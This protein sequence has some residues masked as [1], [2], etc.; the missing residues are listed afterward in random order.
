MN[1]FSDIE[2]AVLQSPAFK[3]ALAVDRVEGL[4]G[5][6]KAL[7]IVRLA[8]E[9]S[10]SR[11]CVI[12]REANQLSEDIRA[13]LGDH[14]TE[15]HCIPDWGESG[16]IRRI[17][18][19]EVSAGSLRSEDRFAR[20]NSKSD[21]SKSAGKKDKSRDGESINAKCAIGNEQLA[22]K[23]AQA[24][25]PVAPEGGEKERG[26]GRR[27]D[28][29]RDRDGDMAIETRRAEE[30]VVH[31]ETKSEILSGLSVLLRWRN[32]PVSGESTTQKEIV[33]AAPIDELPL[34]DLLE[35]QTVR[36]RK[37]RIASL[38][39]N[40]RS[41]HSKDRF[42]RSDRKHIRESED[43]S[44]NIRTVKRGGAQARMPVAPEGGE[45]ERGREGDRDR[46][47]QI[48]LDMFVR[49]LDEVGF[50]RVGTVEEI[51]EF[52]VRGGIADLWGYG[53]RFPVRIEWAADG[54]E[55]IREFDPL[56]QTSI[57]ALEEITVMPM[58]CDRGNAAIR[59][60][61]SDDVLVILDEIPNAKPAVRDGGL[62]CLGEGH[63][64]GALPSYQGNMRVFRDVME[65]L[66]GYNVFV[67]CDNE[68][69]E[70]R[71]NSIFG[72]WNHPEQ[73]DPSVAKPEVK[74]GRISSG[75][76][77]ADAKLAVFS[78]ADIFGHKVRIK[79]RHPFKGR[80]V[81]IED[82]TSL[83][84]GDIVVHIDYG[85]GIY[86]GLDK[87]AIDDSRTDC[88][89]IEYKNGDK[90]YIP[91][92]KFHLVE[93]WAGPYEHAPGLTTL[94]SGAWERK[95]RRAK[96]R[97]EDMTKELLSLYAER[98]LADGY[99]FSP[100]TVW[101]AELESRFPYE[102]TEDQLKVI[103][104]VKQ[105]MESK[106]PMDRLVCGEVG[107]GKTE[108]ALRA[109]FKAV[110]DGKQVALLCPTTILAE[111]H[112]RTFTTRL[113]EFP[114]VVEQLSRFRSTVQQKKTIESVQ[115][116][117]VDIV[118]GTHRLLS[119][120]VKFKDLGLIV[121]DEEHRFGVAQKEKLKKMK[122]SVGILSLTATPIPRTLY[123]SLT[124]LRDFSE[125][126]TAPRG[127]QPVITQMSLWD[128]ALI[129]QALLREVS[130]GGQVYFVHNRI[131]S[132][133][134]V[135][136]QI[137]NMHP[138]FN[139]RVAHA[140]LSER[141]L[142][143]IMMEFMDGDI[144]ILVTTAIIGS[145]I[146]ITRV[147]TI[148]IDRADRFGLAELHQLRGRVGRSDKRAYCYL[149]VPRRLTH[150]AKKRLQAV[151]THTELGAGF[152][153][154]IRDL[155]IR[156]AGNL[157]G[158]EQHGDINAVGYDLYM[159]LLAEKIRS[160]KGEKVVERIE[161]E[162]RLGVNCYIPD[163][164]VDTGRKLELYKRLAACETLAQID[165]LEK[166]LAD[167]F[168]TQPP[169]VRFLLLG[170]RIKILALKKGIIRIQN[171]KYGDEQNGFEIVFQTLP[172]DLDFGGEVVE[173]VNP[174]D[175]GVAIG[176][177]LDGV[178]ELKALLEKA[179]KGLNIED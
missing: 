104:E 87:L 157:L 110:M 72:M 83:H 173:Y 179:G 39:V 122:K 115:N 167:R 171:R 30:R 63:S 61:V 134:I 57:A 149:L 146:D 50:N 46:E 58:N 119:K 5:S 178:E 133:E 99:T 2:A 15:V 35:E 147:N 111:Q 156:G 1:G 77:L 109:A 25:M 125:L 98:K 145:G 143:R 172:R 141:E 101:Q 65:R 137:R 103:E 27:G 9:R 66:I 44:E 88:L 106:Y 54:I 105:D 121:L 100:D 23:C 150:D 136:E 81:G 78:Y 76:I 10:L 155:E 12:S 29:D 97:I 170:A 74:I 68:A 107:Y 59:D 148:I 55:S 164:Y 144:S 84:P 93:R 80:G 69:G 67:I 60:Y 131:Q 86:R 120:D 89:I 6:L 31:P 64:V 18:S 52:A 138:G 90:L 154:A 53:M 128:D 19:L 8:K 56:L 92:D 42:A 91:V 116:G 132:I 127:R 37:R 168:G 28:R 21:S 158:S 40:V 177:R 166:E 49:K 47:Q 85:I 51:G 142:E 124:K 169:S 11:I 140:E 174:V 75:F 162:V 7:Y 14:E 152:K 13:W 102:E 165:E 163:S 161:P 70:S 94:D 16:E 96:K 160:L 135:A 113:G 38:E 153:L 108:V 123:M 45:K 71:I 112:F 175:E 176:L 95:K 22:E 3:G 34:P 48:G 118:I 41:L 62:I 159:R 139:V 26:R 79:S 36:V 24:R 17:A 114:V 32:E 20:N 4:P 73:G 126:S 33:V 129:E 151:M 117:R 82:L 130:R 43:Q